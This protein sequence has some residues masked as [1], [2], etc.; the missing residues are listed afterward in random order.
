MFIRNSVRNLSKDSSKVSHILVVTLQF[1]YKSI[2][3]ISAKRSTNMCENYFQH[4]TLCIVI[5][6]YIKYL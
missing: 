4:K 1:L 5:G 2:L 6:T 3:E